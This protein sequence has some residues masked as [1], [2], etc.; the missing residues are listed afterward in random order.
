MRGL[1]VALDRQTGA[2]RWQTS[3][4]DAVL[5]AVAY[6]DGKLI[7]PLRTGEVA[8]LAVQ[9]GQVLWRT[10]VSGKAPVLAGCAFTGRRI[11]A[12]SSD[13]YLAVLDPR[14][15]KV[16][17]KTYVNHQARPGT[18]LTVSTPQIVGGRVFVGSETGGL[19]CF[20]GSE[21]GE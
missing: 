3:F 16:L 19:H 12:L 15:G 10:H 6:R 11:Y 4:A 1:V 20:V 7:C 14:N 21:S 5:G 9:D 17:E 13:G 2:L 8:A 18:G